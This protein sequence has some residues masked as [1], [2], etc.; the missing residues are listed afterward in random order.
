MKG[1]QRFG[2]ANLELKVDPTTRLGAYHPFI[3]TQRDS[4]SLLWIRDSV[5]EWPNR[6]LD[7]TG[8]P[9]T[10]MVVLSAAATYSKSASV[11]YRNND[12]ELSTYVADKGSVGELQEDWSWYYG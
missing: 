6:T 4:D 10:G 7:I 3:V 12:G 9:G 2:L 1:K 5:T 11:L 8:S